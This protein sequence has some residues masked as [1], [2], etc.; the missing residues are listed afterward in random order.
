[1]SSDY[2]PALFTPEANKL[3]FSSLLFSLFYFLPTFLM[4]RDLQVWE[5]LSIFIAYFVFLALYFWG[6]KCDSSRALRPILALLTLCYFITYITPGSNALFGFATFLSGYYLPV[7]RAF[8]MLGLAL[9]IE[10]VAFTWWRD[11]NVVSL[12]IA[13]FLSLALFVYAVFLRKDLQHRCAEGRDQ[14]QIQQLA[15]I[16]ERER[17]SR[18]LHDLLGHSLSC[19]ALKAELADKLSQAGD[20][21]AA[22][23]EI[24]AVADL[25]RSALSDVR[26]SVSGLKQKGLCAELEKLCKGLQSAGFH[27]QCDNELSNRYSL[28]A[29]IE[30]SIILLLK[31]ASTNIFRHSNGSRAKLHIRQNKDALL[32]TV[33]DNGQL[34]RL[35]EG[36]GIKGMR[37]RCRSMGGKF[38]LQY[39]INGT[40]IDVCI[41]E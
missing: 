1:M 31:E 39:S 40:L 28:P 6:L 12:G 38:S 27:T 3:N 17:I 2:T 30:S 15:T 14:L 7:V 10:L 23:K 36:N 8:L 20:C 35:D 41:P 13:A 5:W 4:T 16:A 18:D 25:T 19:I 32:V 22:A 33:W 26:E 9:L 21:Q 11:Y 29:D 24:S 34:S 37:E